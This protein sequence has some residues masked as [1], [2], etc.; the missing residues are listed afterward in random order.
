MGVASEEQT[1][2]SNLFTD[3]VDPALEMPVGLW[4]SVVASTFETDPS[5][6]T[7]SLLPVDVIDFGFG[8][9]GEEMPTDHHMGD[10]G[11]HH[12]EHLYSSAADDFGI[13]SDSGIDIDSYDVDD[14]L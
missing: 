10:P 11:A 12:H 8:E 4:E 1:W 6:I 5:T 14:E 7:D 9:L 13:E 3:S 2:W